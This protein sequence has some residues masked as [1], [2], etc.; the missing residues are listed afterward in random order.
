MRDYCGQVH[1]GGRTHLNCG[2]KYSKDWGLGLD[3]KAN[4]ER[5]PAFMSSC[6]LSL[7]AAQPAA[8]VLADVTSC[9]ETVLPRTV[10]PNQL[11]LPGLLSL[12]ITPLRRGP[13]SAIPDSEYSGA[14]R[15]L[16][17]SSVLGTF[18]QGSLA[19][20]GLVFS[21]L[22]PRS[23]ICCQ[24]WFYSRVCLLFFSLNARNVLQCSHTKP[25]CSIPVGKAMV[26]TQM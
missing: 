20:L 25:L 8:S 17:V 6:I 26:K 22:C 1:R 12:G 4:R 9:H 18:H 16:P 14:H 10:T 3:E 15:T 19:I 21:F 5:A 2:G 13:S 23:D 24:D 11:L 7:N